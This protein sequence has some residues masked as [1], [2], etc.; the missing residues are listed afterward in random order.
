MGKTS[1][2]PKFSGIQ[3]ISHQDIFQSHIKGCT[4]P[5]CLHSSF[6]APPAA[7]IPGGNFPRAA[8]EGNRGKQTPN[9]KW[10]RILKHPNESHSLS[11]AKAEK[12]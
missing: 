3:E 11:V 7:K 4:Q 10:E 5:F 2:N 1:Q 6:L 12:F 9:K 8:N